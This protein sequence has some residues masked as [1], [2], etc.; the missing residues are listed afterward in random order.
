MEDETVLNRLY[1]NKNVTLLFRFILAFTLGLIFSPFADGIF[2][3]IL[4]SL[5]SELLCYIF[6]GG[7]PQYFNILHKPLIILSY[8][9][10]WLIGR[11]FAMPKENIIHHGI[12]CL[13]NL[14]VFD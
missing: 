11:I 12:P 2:F 9:L 6:T 5:L 8:I 10:G 1:K 7:D 3:L 13:D 14:N 4:L